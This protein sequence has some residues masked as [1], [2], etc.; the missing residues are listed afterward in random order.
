MFDSQDNALAFRD[1]LVQQLD[2][3]DTAGWKVSPTLEGATIKLGAGTARVRGTLDSAGYRVRD[4]TDSD[5]TASG[6][7]SE[8]TVKP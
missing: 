7:E 5:V 3:A 1:D 6:W 8:L 2:R 4:T